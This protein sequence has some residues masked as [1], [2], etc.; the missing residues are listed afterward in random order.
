MILVIT[1]IMITI[2]TTPTIAPMMAVL[3]LL[4]TQSQPI[5]HSYIHKGSYVN[6]MT[7]MRLPLHT[8]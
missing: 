4:L 6:P 7:Q 1:I 2:Q 3:L 8:N 5:F